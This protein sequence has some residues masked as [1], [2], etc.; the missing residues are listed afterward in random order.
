MYTYRT[1]RGSIIRSTRP[2]TGYAEVAPGSV[3]AI[4]RA[5]LGDLAVERRAGP[6]GGNIL[7][8]SRGGRVV[9][10]FQMSVLDSPIRFW[11]VVTR[12]NMAGVSPY[13]V[14][15]SYRAACNLCRRYVGA[16]IR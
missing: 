11:R 7:R 13:L 12:A 9:D 10:L 4:L 8:Y 6:F 5:H 15:R 2:L 1:K 14:E 3:P 16:P